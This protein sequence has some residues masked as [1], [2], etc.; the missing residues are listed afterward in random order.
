MKP[1]PDFLNIL[2]LPFSSA[3]PIEYMKYVPDS[4]EFRQH[5][6]SNGPY[7]IVKYTPTKEFRLERNPAWDPKTDTLRKAYV[8]RITVTEGLTARVFNSSSRPE[9]P[10][11][12]GRAPP[13]Q[14]P[15]APHQLE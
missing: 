10:R 6:I 11:W 9:Q 13:S 2:A 8:D 7:K 14:G 15:P 4:A 1:A 5:T 3:R 12:S